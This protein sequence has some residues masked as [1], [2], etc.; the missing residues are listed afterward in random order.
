MHLELN[1]KSRMRIATKHAETDDESV[2]SSS[3]LLSVSCI[4]CIFNLTSVHHTSNIIITHPSFSKIQLQKLSLTSPASRSKKHAILSLK[5]D[6]LA[7]STMNSAL[8]SSRPFVLTAV[9]QNGLALQY[10]ASQ[11]RDNKSVVK[12]ALMQNG[13]A[14]QYAGVAMR[15]DVNLAL[16]AC[17]QNGLALQYYAGTGI[18]NEK[19][20]VLAAVRSNGMALQYAST[21]M[22]NDEEV[23]TAAVLRN[24]NAVVFLGS[25][26][27]SGKKKL[28]VSFGTNGGGGNI[29]DNV[30]DVE[31]LADA[32]T[33]K[34][35]MDASRDWTEERDERQIDVRGDRV[36]ECRTPREREGGLFVGVRDYIKNSLQKKNEATVAQEVGQE[37][38]VEESTAE[39]VVPKQPTESKEN[40]FSFFEN[41]G[42]YIDSTCQTTCEMGENAW[43]SVPEPLHCKE[44]LKQRISNA[45]QT[46]CLMREKDWHLKEGIKQSSQTNV[47]PNSIDIIMEARRA[48]N[49]LESFAKDAILPRD[50]ARQKSTMEGGLSAC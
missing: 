8:R 45:R 31:S 40:K 47:V 21:D 6:G 32:I 3:S 48:E 15:N 11:L 4:I 7:L 41:M 2:N 49:D 10:A 50:E 22:R 34:V 38:K 28:V 17:R 24:E 35:M 30:N 23:V 26:Y 19:D 13:L 9:R 46:N 36:L 37:I 12:A 27:T 44:V 18:T 43:Q 5:Q 16:I 1:S 25:D 14:V 39:Q 33:R 20:V 42:K 29:T